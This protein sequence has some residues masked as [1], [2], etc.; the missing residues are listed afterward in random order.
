MKK[1]IAAALVSGSVLASSAQAAQDGAYLPYVGMDYTY[2][3]ANARFERPHYN[4]GSVNVGTMYNRFFGT[5]VFYQLSDSHKIRHE[6]DKS[7]TSFQAY[8]LDLYGYLPFGCYGTFTLLGTVG[9]GEYT[10]RKDFSFAKKQRDHGIGWRAGL[11]AMF[12]IDQ[13]WGLR[14]LARYVNLNQ[15]EDFDHMMEYS[16][17]IRYTF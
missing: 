2:S 7:K 4:S 13:H 8:G 9:G 16:A 12:N 11:G 14:L 10:F 17:G 6:T 5:E 1:I 3:D 15:V